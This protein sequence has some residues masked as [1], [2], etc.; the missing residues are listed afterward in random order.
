MV[1]AGPGPISQNL[2]LRLHL[3]QRGG[4]PGLMGIKMAGAG[5][6][7]GLKGEGG[8]RQELGLH[9]GWGAGRASGPSFSKR[10]QQLLGGW[11]LG[12]WG[13]GKEAGMSGVDLDRLSGLLREA[14]SGALPRGR[15]SE[16]LE[17][18]ERFAELTRPCWD[19]RP[20]RVPKSFWE[21]VLSFVLLKHI[22]QGSRIPLDSCFYMQSTSGQTDRK[23]SLVIYHLPSACRWSV[24]GI[25]GAIAVNIDFNNLPRFAT[26]DPPGQGSS[27]SSVSGRS[28]VCT[29]CGM[30][31]K[32]RRLIPSLLRF[33]TTSVISGSSPPVALRLPNSRI[34]VGWSGPSAPRQRN[35]NFIRGAIITV[36]RG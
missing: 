24:S 20:G 2:R 14:L 11:D 9:G 16:A 10:V 23:A 3:Q 5:C 7:K 18:P 29:V 36:L 30:V 1:A 27:K 32:N 35:L 12:A 31:W 21:M 4:C 13:T 25:F 8:T 34:H 28:L 17:W 15:R 33:L 6:C 22:R 19:A 26:P